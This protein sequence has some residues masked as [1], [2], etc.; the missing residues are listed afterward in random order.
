MASVDLLAADG[1]FAQMR[2]VDTLAQWNEPEP[3]FRGMLVESGFPIEIISY[4]RPLR[5]A[6][7]TMISV[8]GAMGAGIVA[9]LVGRMLWRLWRE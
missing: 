5:A 2:V 1:D 6:G 4:D 3:F 8:I 7:E 9:L